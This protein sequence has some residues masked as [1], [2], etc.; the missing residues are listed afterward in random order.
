[1]VAAPYNYK[2]ERKAFFLRHCVMTKMTSVALLLHA[3]LGLAVWY[4]QSAN[5]GEV[6]GRIV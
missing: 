5:S 4:C 2:K 3:V 1:M 6:I